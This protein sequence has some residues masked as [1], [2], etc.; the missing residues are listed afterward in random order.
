MHFSCGGHHYGGLHGYGFHGGHHLSRHVGVLAVPEAVHHAAGA[1]VHTHEYP[2]VGAHGADHYAVDT[3]V[4]G[5]TGHVLGYGNGYRGYG[6]GHGYGGYG[7]GH[8]YGGHGY[9]HGYG[10]GR[11]VHVHHVHRE[12]CR[13]VHVLHNTHHGCGHGIALGHHGAYIAA[14]DENSV[15][16]SQPETN[17]EE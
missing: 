8:G 10:P 4:A 5:H 13:S 15:E 1:A 3:H 12:P 17:Q 11:A 14:N 2:H 6:Y 9:G 16:E 7:Y